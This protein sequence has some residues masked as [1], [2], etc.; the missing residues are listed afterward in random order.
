M[1][2]EATFGTTKGVCKKT[3]PGTFGFHAPPGRES[4]AKA[5]WS[6]DRSSNWCDYVAN[7]CF[8]PEDWLAEFHV[9]QATFVYFCDQLKSSISKSDTLMRKAVSTEKRVAITLWFL[10]TGVD[11]KRSLC[12]YCRTFVA[13]VHQDPDWSSFAIRHFRVDHGFPQCVGAV[14]GTHIPIVSPRECP[15]DY[16]NRKGWHSIILQGT[17]DHG[18]DECTMPVF[19]YH[20]GQTSS[21]LPNH[22]VVVLKCN[23]CKKNHSMTL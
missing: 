16:Y 21:P 3:S 19:L 1:V 18:L 8:T 14:D 5:L 10:S 9:S 2:K 13:G 20:R 22:P 7:S 6:K 23:L 11:H 17:V 12:C 4:P 15:A